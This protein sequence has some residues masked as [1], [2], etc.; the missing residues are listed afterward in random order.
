MA[1][2]EVLAQR[3]KWSIR[4]PSHRGNDQI[5]FKGVIADFHVSKQP[6]SD[7]ESSEKLKM[8]TGMTCLELFEPWMASL[9]ST[10]AFAYFW[11]V[12]SEASRRRKATSRHI[13]VSA[14]SAKDKL[15]RV[16]NTL[17]DV[18]AAVFA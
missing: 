16:I 10:K 1:C 7:L 17:L 11:P 13:K 14:I 2:A 6:V 5:I 9:P 15:F 12:K 8:R 18:P 4:H 3:A